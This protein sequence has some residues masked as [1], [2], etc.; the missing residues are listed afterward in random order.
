MVNVDAYRNLLNKISIIEKLN[1]LEKEKAN[2][3]L[4]S[5][6]NDIVELRNFIEENC[7]EYTDISYFFVIYFIIVTSMLEVNYTD[8][9][10][11]Y[12]DFQKI[13]EILQDSSI[14]IDL[15]NID[16]DNEYIEK[17]KR[18]YELLINGLNVDKK[19]LKSNLDIAIEKFWNIF[20][21]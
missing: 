16:N 6:I 7:K 3:K 19:D 15:D 5:K 21:E 8:D 2:N 13:K 4:N 9:F 12:K 1:K 17:Y 20:K 10:K 14:K 18:D 11:N